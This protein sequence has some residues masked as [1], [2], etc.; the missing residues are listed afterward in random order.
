M[1]YEMLI[2]LLEKPA[3]L[4]KKSQAELSSL[5]GEDF[6]VMKD[7]SQNNPHH[8]YN[9]LEHTV[10]TIEALDFKGLD[11]QDVAD[12]KVAAL[13]HDIGKPK[14]A[15]YKNGRT[16]FYNH[17]KASK[18]IAE[19][20][21]ERIGTDKR[22]VDRISF[23]V[24]YH[25]MFISF[26]LSEENKAKTNPYIKEITS[27]S[28]RK[29]IENLVRKRKNEGG[30]VPSYQDFSV[31]LHLCFADACAQ[32]ERAISDGKILDTRANKLKRLTEIKRIIDNL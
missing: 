18:D 21:L 15:F 13:Y 1:N 7:Y 5:L 24:E 29:E 17:A 9:L 8:C 16:V 11:E 14:V 6:S 31:L 19:R 2:E 27:Q 25:D 32:S 23:F 26:K 20:E 4:L 28:V 3:G 12:L 10:R 22:T 30:F